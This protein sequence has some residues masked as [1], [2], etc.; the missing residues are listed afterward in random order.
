VAASSGQA[1]FDRRV[2]LTIA[3]PV[4]T[5]NDF[6]HVTTDVIEID[7]GKTDDSDVP[8]MRI[9]FKIDKTL[10][11]EPN[12]SQ[13]VVTNLSPDRRQSLQKKGVKVKL[14]AGYKSTGIQVIFQGDVR[15]IDHVRNGPS[16]DTTMKLGDGLRA[17]KFARVQES[18]APGVKA[19]DVVKKLAQATGLSL[20]NINSQANKIDKVFDQG[21]SIGG[22]AVNGFD[23]IVKSLGKT[24]SIQDG[25]LQILDPY[26]ALSLPIPDITPDTG[27]VGSPEMG[28]PATKGKPALLKFKALLFVI[29]PGAKVKLKSERYNGYIRVHRLSYTGDTHGGEWYTDIDGTISQ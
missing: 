16:W 14:E 21:W 27:L 17:W 23:K 19:A 26:E 18:F 4:N 22:S 6:T 12:T 2:K 24:W 29:R 8:G 9:S 28:S 3:N 15:T 1:L 5:P 10:E 13:I 11:K 7:G 20:G 25:E